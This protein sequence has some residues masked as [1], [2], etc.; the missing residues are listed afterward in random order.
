MSI[1]VKKLSLLVAVCLW[2][3]GTTVRNGVKLGPGK[4]RYIVMLDPAGDAQH[5]G[6]SLYDGFER[7]SALQCAQR[8][9][10]LIEY[11][12]PYVQVVLTHGPRETVEPLQNATF[13]NHVG[14]A[15]YLHIGFY[16]EQRV[17]SQVYLYHFS[18]KNGLAATPAPLSFIPHDK[19]YL[20]NA[21][22]TKQLAKKIERI[23]GCLDYQQQFI[24]GGTFAVPCKPLLGVTAPAFAVEIG[25]KSG[26]DWALYVE[27]LIES[28]EAVLGHDAVQ[29]AD[30]DK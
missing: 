29:V 7:G 10:E 3:P 23:L 4:K 1:T 26:E 30:N 27:P 2:L 24:F 8:I 25:L 28:I 11:R 17:K 15:L 21:A 18:Y 12:H 19:A 6:R 22:Q 20:G 13:A 14:A 5:T 9:K 16:A